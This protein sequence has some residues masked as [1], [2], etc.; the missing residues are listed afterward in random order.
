MSLRYLKGIQSG[1]TFVQQ[2][3][4][5]IKKSKMQMALHCINSGKVTFLYFNSS[6]DRIYKQKGHSSGIKFMRK[7]TKGLPWS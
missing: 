4:K 6:K 7:L 1:T 2:S 5:K 3:K